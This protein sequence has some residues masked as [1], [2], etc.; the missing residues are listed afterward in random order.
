M[1]IELRPP[2]PGEEGQLRTLFTQAFGDE[3]DFTDLFFRTAY[4][5]ERC[6]VAAEGD[7][8]AALYW[9]DCSLRGRK[10]AYL[11]AIATKERCRGKGIGTKLI[12]DTLGHLAALGYAAAMLVPAQDHLFRYYARLGFATVGHIR[13]ETVPAGTPIPVRKLT[14][15]EYAAL[16]RTYLPENAILQEGPAL[17][18]LN[19]YADFYASEKALAAVSRGMVWELLGDSSAAPGILAVLGIP[20]A[21]IRSPGAG[22]PF[23]MAYG[24]EE[25]VYLGLA[26]D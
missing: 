5:P 10:V 19:G 13:E 9:F 16:R 1:T 6:R 17:E 12:G 8:L 24:L 22:R 7:I 26:L 23:A 2:R 21:T 20:Q 11:Y 4:A 18:L 3:G 25:P 14:V 15:C